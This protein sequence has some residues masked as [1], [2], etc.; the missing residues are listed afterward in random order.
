MIALSAA[1]ASI[2]VLAGLTFIAVDQRQAA[3]EQENVAAARFLAGHAVAQESTA[4]SQ[5]LRIRALLAAESLRKSWTDEGYRAW[6]QATLLMPPVLGETYTDSLFIRMVFTPDSKRLFALCGDRHIHVLSVPDLQELRPPLQASQTTFGLAID[7]KG[8]S[9]LAYQ[10]D[11]DSVELF[12]IASGAKRTVFLPDTYRLA[13]FNPS[14][15]ALVA[16]LT[17]LWV[18][19]AASDKVTSRATFP[20]STADVAM[21]P[22]G[23]TAVARSRDRL[24]AYDTASGMPRWQVP[25]SGGEEWHDAVFSGDGQSLLVKGLRNALIISTTSGETIASNPLQ[26]ESKGRLMLFSRERYALGNVVHHTDEG[27]ERPLPFR[28]D[29]SSPLMRPVASPSGRYVAGTLQSLEDEFAIVDVARGFESVRQ[30]KAD[31][32]VTLKVAQAARVAAFSPDNEMLAVS[33]DSLANG[34]YAGE[35]QLISLKRERWSPIIPGRS[36]TGD[37]AVVPPDAQ[38]VVRK[39]TPTTRIFD[40]GGAPLDGAGTGSF[41][42][43]SGRFV[44]RDEGTEWVITDTA[45]NR[46]IIVPANDGRTIEFSPDERRVL[47]F[48]N[49]YRLDDPGSPQVLEAAQPFDRTW[50]Y[51]GVNLVI[52]RNH[53]Q[54]IQDA[55]GDSVFFDWATGRVSVGPGSVGS[56]YAVSPDGRHFATYDYDSISIWTV[57]DSEAT[58]RSPARTVASRDT[59]L[60]FSPDGSLLAVA[61]CMGLP[62]YDTRTLELAYRVPM[63]GCFAGFSPDGKYVLSR[64]WVEGFPEPTRHPITLEGVLEETCAKVRTNLSAQEWERMG[65]TAFAVATCPEAAADA[66]GDAAASK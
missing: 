41:F 21:S 64:W 59:P 4:S 56:L 20:E 46:D 51:P 49:I 45:N 19:D 23:A 35:L 62:L 18:V 28:E 34:G 24:V 52:G 10:A 57:G 29:P 7:V 12:E 30:P 47:V 63:R 50:S 38:V 66:S 5:G 40:S 65:A 32:Y 37:V 60:H 43:A 33:L 17:N 2:V 6:R 9:A 25:A 1:A 42:S 27:L 22:D 26:P 16:S 31:F 55:A 3:R 36:G 15:E 39:G 53:D 13:S 11:S 44:A 14:G 54:I 8:E 58:V 61:S 48:P